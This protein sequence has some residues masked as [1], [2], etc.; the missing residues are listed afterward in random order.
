MPAVLVGC[1]FGAMVGSLGVVLRWCRFGS[2]KQQPTPWTLQ[3]HRQQKKKEVQIDS[4]AANL[5]QKR[6]P[7]LVEI[8]LMVT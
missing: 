1:C 7:L 6:K 2:E 3:K 4:V 8:V 5:G